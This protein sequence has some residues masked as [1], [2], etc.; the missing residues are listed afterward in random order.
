[1]NPP[2]KAIGSAI[3]VATAYPPP[4]KIANAVQMAPAEV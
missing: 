3:A 4:V 2:N 1:M